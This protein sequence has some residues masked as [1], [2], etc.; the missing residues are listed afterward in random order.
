MTEG[1]PYVLIPIGNKGQ[2]FAIPLSAVSESDQVALLPIGDKGQ[3]VAVP[4]GSPAEGDVTPLV[5]I[6]NKNQYV[7]LGAA[8]IPP[9]TGEIHWLGRDYVWTTANVTTP[10]I[11]II[12]PNGVLVVD[13]DVDAS[14]SGPIYNMSI[15]GVWKARIF[16]GAVALYHE[17]ETVT[18]VIEDP[19]FSSSSRW[20]IDPNNAPNLAF[21]FGVADGAGGCST[22]LHIYGSTTINGDTFEVKPTTFSSGGYVT[23]IE[24]YVKRGNSNTLCYGYRSWDSS[25]HWWDLFDYSSWTLSAHPLSA[26]S[27]YDSGVGVGYIEA[28]GY[29]WADDFDINITAFYVYHGVVTDTGSG[30]G[31]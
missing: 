12:N 4:I 8:A 9:G 1:D 14:G 22:S 13:A 19:C 7:A 25:F 11:H 20:T 17:Y 5:P 18:Q 15:E 31:I 21:D 10:H 30:P 29:P 24:L 2:Y 3:Y 28:G 6:G 23:F 27:S 26:Q 16:N